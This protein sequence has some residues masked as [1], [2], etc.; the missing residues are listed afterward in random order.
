MCHYAA[1]PESNAAV[2]SKGL[3]LLDSGGQYFGG[4][5]DGTRTLAFGPVD[6]ETKRAYTA[7][8]KCFISLITLKFPVGTF[9]HQIDAFARRP[10]WELGLDYDHG[11]GHGV[12]HF[13]SVHENPHRFEQ[14]ANPYPL[15]AG[16]VM[17]I[18]PGLYV[19]G[20][21]GMRIENQVELV[22][23]GGGFLKFASLTLAPI[24]LAPADLGLATAEELA[25]LDGYHRQ[26]REALLPRI[27]PAYRDYLVAA[28]KAIDT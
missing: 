2:T 27:D 17:T 20:K 11:A 23:A 22:D 15:V 21:F 26:V 5:T 19:E 10:L 8:L 3:Y 28:T 12:G 14:R 13:L 24:D 18:E 4:T 6:A 1:T 16:L 7:V 25:F 9:G